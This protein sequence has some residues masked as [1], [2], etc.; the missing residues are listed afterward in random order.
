MKKF[1][2]L[3]IL[4]ILLFIPCLNSNAVATEY[5]VDCYSWNTCSSEGDQTR[6]CQY[7]TGP[8]A[9]MTYIETRDC[10]PEQE[11]DFN[12]N[13]TFDKIEPE[14]IVPGESVVTITGNDFGKTK[15]DSYVA[16]VEVLDYNYISDF[17]S[18]SN[19]EIQFNAPNDIS[20]DEIQVRIGDRYGS[21]HS[22]KNYYVQPSIKSIEPS[23]G[24]SG[25]IVK[26]DLDKHPNEIFPGDVIVDNL[27]GENIKNEVTIDVYFNKTK[28]SDVS[29]DKYG[30]Y[31]VEIPQ[32][33]STG[34]IKVELYTP[35]SPKIKAIS[36]EDFVVEDKVDCSVYGDHSYYNETNE[37]C[38][39]KWGYKWNEN[40]TNCIEDVKEVP[41]GDDPD[42]DGVPTKKDLFPEEKSEV[43]TRNYS[44]RYKMPGD[45]RGNYVS[46]KI[47]VPKDLYLYYQNEN[48]LFGEDFENIT[49]FVKP[50]DPVIIDIANQISE[51]KREQGLNPIALVH[52]LVGEII[53]TD[54]KFSIKGWD[55]YPKYPVETILEKRGDCEDTSFLMA[56]LFK[57]LDLS[58]PLLVKFNNHLGVSV[59]ASKGMI[60]AVVERWGEDFMHEFNK[61][62]K[63]ENPENYYGL[64]YLETTGNAY[65]VPGYMPEEL[66]SKEYEV[67]P[68]YDNGADNYNEQTDNNT[69]ESNIS[70]KEAII[71]R[72]KNA[73]QEVDKNLSKKVSGKILLQVESKGEGWYIDPDDEKK[74]Y[75]GRPIDAIRIM[76]ELGL[77]ISESSYNSFDGHAPERLAG[78]ILL[79]VD[80]SGEAYY[81]NPEDLKMHYLGRPADAFKVMRNLGLGISNDNI[82]RIGVGEI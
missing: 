3:T 16:L 46:F 32:G 60:D 74:Y 7:L 50:D 24:Y 19:N 73:L 76:R 69:G 55:E 79:R 44:F 4:F 11:E 65:W 23:S 75:L 62:R 34:K 9:G 26:I 35:T 71:Q 63:E 51:Y 64:M 10:T 67:I 37:E 29:S 25:D 43:I 47:D 22:F 13:P 31:N 27:L 57:A 52:Q 15:G 41:A 59:I 14:I 30:Y 58:D 5:D 80:A 36:D 56:S 39:C 17:K 70:N 77:G 45:S 68:I 8:N 38:I 78:K 61:H 20:A 82:R 54:D 49:T 2:Q 40:K 72:E 1:I 53:Y 18:W 28:I 81:V 21:Y 48:H 33:A 12:L 42:N 6:T 66:R